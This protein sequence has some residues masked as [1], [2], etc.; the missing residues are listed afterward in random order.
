MDADFYMVEVWK[1]TETMELEFFPQFEFHA[2]LTWLAESLRNQIN[3]WTSS[4]IRFYHHIY[5]IIKYVQ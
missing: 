5:H 2:F 1:F 4:I 3:S